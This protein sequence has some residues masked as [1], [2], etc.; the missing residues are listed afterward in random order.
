MIQLENTR[1]LTSVRIDARWRH[2]PDEMQHVTFARI[3]I[4][5]KAGNESAQRL[6]RHIRRNLCGYA[7]CDCG[8]VHV[9]YYEPYKPVRCTN[10]GWKNRKGDE[11]LHI[12]GQPR[13]WMCGICAAL[14]LETALGSGRFV[15]GLNRDMIITERRRP[16]RH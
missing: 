13:R 1:H 4:A 5:A 8:G 7:D 6:E 3:C 14:Y 11:V 10:C 16:P 15:D 2:R 9:E 12:E